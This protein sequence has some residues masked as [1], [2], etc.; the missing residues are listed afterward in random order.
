MILF[1]CVCELGVEFEKYKCSKKCKFESKHL[2]TSLWFKNVLP[3]VRHKKFYGTPLWEGVQGPEEVIFLPSG[4]PHTILNLEDNVAI[5]ENYLLADGLIQLTKFLAL[6]L[7][8]VFRSKWAQSAWKR[9]YFSPKLK[10]KDRRLMKRTYEHIIDTL[11][12]DK[13]KEV[14]KE[15]LGRWVKRHAENPEKY[16]KILGTLLEKFREIDRFRDLN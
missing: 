11:D 15:A 5:T 4:L 12:Y 7:I 16:G 14:E 13:C 8:S 1:L 3:Q 6:D 2:T 10:A 9:F